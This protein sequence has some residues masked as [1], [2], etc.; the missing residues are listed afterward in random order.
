MSMKPDDFEP[1][2]YITVLKGRMSSPIS[3]IFG[4]EVSTEVLVEDRSWKGNVLLVKAVDI[5]YLVVVDCQSKIKTIL[6]IRERQFKKLSP[7]YVEAL[8]DV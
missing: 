4:G 3:S 7:D 6:D 1:G 5:P 2:Q 8:K